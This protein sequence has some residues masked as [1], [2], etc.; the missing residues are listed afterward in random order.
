MGTSPSTH[1]PLCVCISLSLCL[2]VCV[3]VCQCTFTEPEIAHVG[4]YPRDMEEKGIAY[5][6][7]TKPFAAVDRAILEGDTEGF[8][9]IHTKQVGRHPGYAW[10]WDLLYVWHVAWW[11]WW[12]VQGSDEI[13]GATIVGPNAGDMISE[14]S[15]AM[16]SKTVCAERR[17]CAPCECVGLSL[18]LSVCV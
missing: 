11:R 14:I 6:T 13:L 8:V 16:E 2:C 1:T 15:V 5:R 7:F 17:V 10:G 4:L 12:C 18:S 3:Y 9:K